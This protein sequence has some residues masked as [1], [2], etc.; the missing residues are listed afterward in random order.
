MSDRQ[1]FPWLART[2]QGWKLQ[3]EVW[4]GLLGFAGLLLGLLSLLA[5][6]VIGPAALWAAGVVWAL[7]GFAHF[8]ALWLK[9]HRIRCP[10]CGHNPT[11]EVASGRWL[12]GEVVHERLAVL[13]LCPSCGYAGPERAV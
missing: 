9:Y 10:W 4:V 13:E 2:G 7:Y 12:P 5:S 1:A 11:R 8:G 6:F 3:A